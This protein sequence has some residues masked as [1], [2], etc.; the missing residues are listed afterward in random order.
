[1]FISCI[2]IYLFKYSLNFIIYL[3]FKVGYISLLNRITTILTRV[4]F[5]KIQKIKRVIVGKK[6]KRPL[7]SFFQIDN[8]KR[9]LDT[10][11]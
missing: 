1:M 4:I 3:S 2:H 8:L 9:K 10:L 11:A 7:L 6:E 5:S